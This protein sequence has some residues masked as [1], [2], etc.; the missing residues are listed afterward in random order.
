MLRLIQSVSSGVQ[1]EQHSSGWIK[2]NHTFF[3]FYPADLFSILP[4]TYHLL[5]FYSPLLSCSDSVSSFIFPLPLSLLIR[6][7][8]HSLLLAF[9]ST[10]SISFLLPLPPSFLPRA[11]LPPF[12]PPLLPAFASFFPSSPQPPPILLRLSSEL[13]LFSLPSFLPPSPPLCRSLLKP[14]LEDMLLQ[15]Q[16]KKRI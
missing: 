3:F 13:I 11:S 5:I 9:I 16:V 1:R 10:S 2:S 15:K 7:R 4:L 6:S 12:H 8:N 14:S